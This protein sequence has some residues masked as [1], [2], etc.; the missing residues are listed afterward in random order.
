PLF[1]HSDLTS[2]IQIS[3]LVAYTV[4]WGVRL[5][6]MRE[7]KRQ[8]LASIADLACRLRY[9]W[10]SQGQG[11]HDVWGFSHITRLLPK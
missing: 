11:E 2:M 1:V 10:R 6:S 5:K 4:S 3:D 8:E 9:H 7:P